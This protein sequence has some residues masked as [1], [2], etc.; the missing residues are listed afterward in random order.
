MNAISALHTSC[1]GQHTEQIVGRKRGTYL[2]CPKMWSL[3]GEPGG[4]G[5]AGRSMGAA[6]EI[7]H[8]SLTAQHHA[9]HPAAN[10]QH[11]TLT[12]FPLTFQ[13]SGIGF[14]WPKLHYIWFVLLWLSVDVHCLHT[15]ELSLKDVRKRV[16]HVFFV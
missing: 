10:T 16:E 7:K 5:L 6:L 3:R 14:G 13:T 2:H 9:Q 8:I 12:Y 15:I 1:S 11:I 4:L